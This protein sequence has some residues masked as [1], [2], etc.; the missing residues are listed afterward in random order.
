[1]LTPQVAF[2]NS[3]VAKPHPSLKRRP[4]TMSRHPETLANLSTFF[5]VFPYRHYPKNVFS[6]AKASLQARYTERQQRSSPARG[7]RS[8]P[9]S[10]AGRRPPATDIFE[11]APRGDGPTAT[12]GSRLPSRQQQQRPSPQKQ[13]ANPPSSSEIQAPH[14]MSCM[15]YSRSLNVLEQVASPGRARHLGG[16]HDLQREVDTE[17]LVEK[18]QQIQVGVP[19]EPC[20][21]ERPT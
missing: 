8:A 16:R 20:C 19:S 7:E 13:V 4:A 18:E 11:A 15:S 9:P 2:D 12:G 14:W 5:H 17:M 6:D 1:M 10:A 3:V 21:S